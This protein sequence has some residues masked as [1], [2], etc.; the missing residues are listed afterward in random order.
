MFKKDLIVVVLI[1]VVLCMCGCS[2]SSQK[3]YTLSDIPAVSDQ[4]DEDFLNTAFN[5]LGIG[6]NNYS[7]EFKVENNYMVVNYPN[8]TT[9]I[10]Q[11]Y[12]ENEFLN[13][14]KIRFIIDGTCSIQKFKPDT[15]ESADLGFVEDD[16]DTWVGIGEFNGYV[17][18]STLETHTG[19]CWEYDTTVEIV[20]DD[21]YHIII[22]SGSELR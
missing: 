1:A 11:M 10:T 21:N 13:E 19:I 14:H 6:F 16:P 3:T 8:S 15:F 22:N 20:I 7:T 4:P 18:E 9:G 2:S 12:A 17:W 5:K